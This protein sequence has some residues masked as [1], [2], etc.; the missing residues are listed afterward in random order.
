MGCGLNAYLA[1]LDFFAGA[2]NLSLSQQLL[3]VL[4]FFERSIFKKG[5]FANELT[6]LELDSSTRNSLYEWDE[7]RI[8]ETEYRSQGKYR[9]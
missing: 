6:S 1:L 8:Q 4:N 2:V 3:E 5:F 7:N 9:L